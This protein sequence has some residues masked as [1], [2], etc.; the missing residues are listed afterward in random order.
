MCSSCASKRRRSERRKVTIEL[1]DFFGCQVMASIVLFLKRERDTRRNFTSLDS[2]GGVGDCPKRNRLVGVGYMPR[3]SASRRTGLVGGDTVGVVGRSSSSLSV[4]AGSYTGMLVG[5][6][7]RLRD[8]RWFLIRFSF[9]IVLL[10]DILLYRLVKTASKLVNPLRRYEDLCI[11]RTEY[12]R[13]V[14]VRTCFASLKWC[15]Y[16]D[17]AR[18]ASQWLVLNKLSK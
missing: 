13:S 7:V 4:I 18:N 6:S 1:H 17:N 15:V 14:Q 5:S 2:R 16:I 8:T 9:R 3:G 12:E 10:A 11:Q